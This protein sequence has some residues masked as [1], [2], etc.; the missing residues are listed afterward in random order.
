MKKGGKIINRS[1]N[2]KGQIMGMPFMFIF[3]LILVAI[4]LF[5]GFWVIRNIMNQAEQ[6]N[7]LLFASENGDLQDEIRSVWQKE[8]ASK[9]KT[10]PLSRK[11]EYVCFVNM[12]RCGIQQGIIPPDFCREAG[13]YGSASD[14]MFLW[15][16]GI[17]E[18]YN[19]KSA[20]HIKCGQKECLFIEKTFCIP[21]ENGKITLKIIKES[22]SSFVKIQSP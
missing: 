17:A 16:P 11:F 9:T 15:P 13:I 18:K 7:I 19:V 21:I 4:A 2:K 1:K 14:N 6:A 12:S 10:F 20:W 8:A 5:V 22:G 3:S